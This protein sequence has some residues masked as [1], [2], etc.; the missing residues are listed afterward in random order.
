MLAANLCGCRLNLDSAW[1]CRTNVFGHCWSSLREWDGNVLVPVMSSTTTNAATAAAKS[2]CRYRKGSEEGVQRVQVV[3]AV[4]APHTQVPRR[5]PRRICSGDDGADQMRAGQRGKKPHGRE[6]GS[7]R[8]D[9]LTHAY[10]SVLGRLGARPVPRIVLETLSLPLKTCPGACE[11]QDGQNVQVL[12]QR[13]VWGQRW[14]ETGL[15]ML[16]EPAVDGIEMRFFLGGW[17]MSVT[18]SL[19]G[20]GD[21]WAGSKLG[22][23][24]EWPG[25]LFREWRPAPRG[26]TPQGLPAGMEG[27][28]RKKKITA[29]KPVEVLGSAHPAKAQWDEA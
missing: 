14:G 20:R 17:T 28:A 26:A 25:V 27:E 6:L 29:R 13:G 7:D 1:R 23:L 15:S 8:W 4:V 3:V 24:R 11:S 5:V 19:T 12:C 2:G 22:N 18:I 9:K 10:Q 21:S 16:M